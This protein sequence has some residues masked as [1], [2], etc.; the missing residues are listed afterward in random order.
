MTARQMVSRGFIVISFLLFSLPVFSQQ[1]RV[2][3]NLID[4]DELS[5]G[6]A[7]GGFSVTQGKSQ[8]PIS[9]DGSIELADDLTIKSTDGHNLS[10]QG[11]NYRGHLGISRVND[12]YALINTLELEDY[13]Y[14]VIASEVDTK[15]WP[16]EALKAQ[17]VVSRSYAATLINAKRKESYDLGTQVSHQVYLGATFE[18]ARAREAV[19]DTKDEVLM[20][21]DGEV[22]PAYFHSCCGGHTED[23][24]AIW[25]ENGPR[26][27]QGV[28][29]FGFCKLSPHYNWVTTLSRGDLESSLRK[30]GY[31]LDSPV[32]A[33]L[34]GSL[35][36]SQR[37]LTLKIVTSRDRFEV[38]TAK[39]REMLGSNWIRSTKITHIK[40]QDKNFL[41]YGKG[42]GHGVGLCQWGAKGMADRGWNYKRIL[43]V[44]FPKAKIAKI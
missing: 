1:I 5:L 33:I 36:R 16:V 40:T 29:D 4:H 31:T 19:D 28:S 22:V 30:L 7:A 34:L 15:T 41:I 23:P 3:L 14:G 12:K 27:V 18:D 38:S 11:K 17:A 6:V 24:Q 13:L 20:D 32:K 39:L 35:S 8:V 42:W 44:Y 2:L 25:N 10:W 37:V 43:K 9:G 26:S 21:N